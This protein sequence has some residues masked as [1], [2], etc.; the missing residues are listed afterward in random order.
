[1]PARSRTTLCLGLS[2]L[3]AASPLLASP[4]PGKGKPGGG[5][6]GV[7]IDLRGPTVDVGRVRIILGE[8]RQLIGPTSSLPPG[9]AKNLARGKPLPPGI[10][11]N[12]DSR[13]SARLP[14]YE[15]YE[16]KQIGRDVVLVA[17][18]TGIVYEILRNVLD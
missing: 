13:L 11:K 9:I 5:H 7:Q 4:P 16:W 17:I 6:D 18:A 8:N 14:Y 12:F 1:M 2:L 15:G 3:L 10:A